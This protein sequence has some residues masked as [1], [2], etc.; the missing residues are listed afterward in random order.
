MSTGTHLELDMGESSELYF[1]DQLEFPGAAGHLDRQRSY[2]EKLLKSAKHHYIW[3]QLK[4]FVGASPVYI[5]M[6]VS[7]KNQMYSDHILFWDWF[8][9]SIEFA[10]STSEI[11]IFFSES[12][13]QVDMLSSLEKSLKKVS[14]HMRKV[15]THGN[16]FRLASQSKK[17]YKVGSASYEGIDS[18]SDKKAIV[19]TEAF[20]KA[21][22]IDLVDGL[23][24]LVETDLRMR[25]NLENQIKG[26]AA[27][28]NASGIRETL[29]VRVLSREFL[30]GIG[31]RLDGTVASITNAILDVDL[32][33]KKVRDKLSK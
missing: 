15:S 18:N 26:L 28:V 6:Q 10:E 1:C 27:K 13:D 23:L 12:Q 17:L 11:G 8:Y 25:G 19:P 3:G 32:D 16:L 14:I 9:S 2:Q 4:K 33:A 22:A 5:G 31:K 20:E 21:T 24:N 29:F 30:D 7:K